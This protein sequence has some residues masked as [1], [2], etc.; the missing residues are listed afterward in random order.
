M[1]LF[2][3]GLMVATSLMLSGCLASSKSAS[4]LNCEYAP[5]VPLWEMPVACQGH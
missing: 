2:L 4:G 1:K 5:G 3:M